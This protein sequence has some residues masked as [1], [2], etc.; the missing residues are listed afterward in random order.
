MTPQTVLLAGATGMLGARIAHHLLDADGT[1]L[2][3]L[4]RPSV[5]D[6][7][8]KQQTLAI[9]R[10]A[11]IV[12]G[13]LTDAASLDAAT[14]DVDVVVSAVQGDRDVVVDGQLALARAAAAN[15]VRRILP[16]D[17][18]LDLFKATPG[19]HHTFDLRREADERIAETG[20]E[21]VNVLNGAFLD[22]AAAPGAMVEFDEQAGIATSWGTG[23]ELF[24]ATTVDDTARFTARAAL[25]TEL[26]AG[27]F[28]VVGDRISFNRI[29]AI[30]EKNTGRRYE[31]RSRGTLDDLRTWADGRRDAG[32]QQGA[33]MGRYLQYMLSGQT[34]LDDV[35]NSRYPDIEPRTLEH[36]AAGATA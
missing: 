25:D 29:I 19:E 2:R 9:E 17:F 1:T 26:P 22:Y 10:G 24:E 12:T 31:R 27:K 16:S 32:D 3:L 7:P 5:Q 13:D 33:L 15:G 35:Q 18:A 30:H 14:R 8:T 23:D 21:Q 6:D 36:V 34:G 28:A 11:E 20:L 4:I